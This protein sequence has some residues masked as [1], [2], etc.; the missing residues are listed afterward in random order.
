MGKLH[1]NDV[2]FCDEMGLSFGCS[3][4][5]TRDRINCFPIAGTVLCFEFS[6]SNV[7]TTVMCWLLLSSAYHKSRT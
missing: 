4:G 6:E 1:L 3:P 5:F 7:D 2:V